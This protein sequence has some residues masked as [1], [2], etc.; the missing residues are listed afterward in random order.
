HRGV[1]GARASA[2]ARRRVLRDRTTHRRAH[3]REAH[4]RLPRAEP[5]RLEQR[6]PLTIGSSAG[7]TPVTAVATSNEPRTKR[8]PRD[9]AAIRT[10]M[11]KDLT[12]VRRSKAIM[13]PMI[14]VPTLLMVILPLG[15]GLFARSAPTEQVTSALD[16][17]LVH[18]M[19][20]PILD[21]PE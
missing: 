18:D 4:R 5:R 3:G 12:A 17:P 10:V 16:S 13:I 15:L 21:L 8:P 14:V 19:V 9:W 20:R 1:R 2:D 6:E 7:G 11:A